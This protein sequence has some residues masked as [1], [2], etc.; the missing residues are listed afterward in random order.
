MNRCG[1]PADQLSR[2]RGTAGF[3]V[4]Q[5]G[6]SHAWDTPS[7]ART[8]PS[9]A[10]AA[11][12][13]SSSRYAVERPIPNSASA[14]ADHDGCPRTVHDVLLLPGTTAVRVARTLSSAAVLPRQAGCCAGWHGWACR[15]RYR[16]RYP[17]WTVAHSGTCWVFRTKAWEAMAPGAGV[18]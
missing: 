17:R 7:S 6:V 18:N 14:Y 13:R 11:A 5:V 4:D 16:G 8:V 1:D 9:I 10:S 2:E 15:S 3:L 12:A